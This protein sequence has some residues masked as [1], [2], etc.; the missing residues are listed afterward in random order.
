M[1]SES[2]SHGGALPYNWMIENSIAPVTSAD[3]SPGLLQVPWLL[4]VPT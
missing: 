2:V 3:G 4:C 1:V